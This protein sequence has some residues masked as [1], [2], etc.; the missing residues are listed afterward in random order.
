MWA[1]A[2]FC[3]AVALKGGATLDADLVVAGIGVR[4]RVELAEKARFYLT[5]R[6]ITL[7]APMRVPS[8]ISAFGP[9][10]TPGAS[11]IPSPSLALG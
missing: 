7:Y 3:A 4:P 6:P 9:M 1:S 5:P 10:I 8:P 11:T 2:S